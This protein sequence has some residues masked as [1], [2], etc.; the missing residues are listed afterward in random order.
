MIR[1]HINHS[2][3]EKVRTVFL[4]IYQVKQK[5]TTK[6]GETADL[7]FKLTSLQQNDKSNSIS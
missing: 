1:E 2:Y 6:I 3:N 7:K 5:E 4:F